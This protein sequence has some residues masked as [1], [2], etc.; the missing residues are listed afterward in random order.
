MTVFVL[1]QEHQNDHG[2][3]ETS[4]NGVFLNREGAAAAQRAQMD[5]A[6]GQGLAIF[7]E[8]KDEADWQVSWAIEE[9]IV[10]S[11]RSP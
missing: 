9:H 11:P 1:V 8:I 4:V 7:G 6:R 10:T 2:F 5:S 3:V